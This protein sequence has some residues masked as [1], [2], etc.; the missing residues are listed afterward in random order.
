M[1]NV[2]IYARYSSHSQN[3]QSIEGQ[4]KACSDFA[5]QKDYTVIGEYIDR[6][7]SGTAADKRPE[8]QRMIADSAKHQFKYIVVY[9]LDRFSRNRYD[10]AVNKAKLKKNGVRLISVR[11]NITDDASGILMESVLEGM[12]EYF[13]AELSQKV[14]RGM[15]ISAS[16]CLSTG[17]SVALG[18]VVDDN[19]MFQIN[20][21]TAPAVVKIFELYAQGNTIAFICDYLNR[22]HIRT[23]RGGLFNKNSLAVLLSN[24]RYIGIY[25]YKGNETPG[26]MP[27][28]VSDELFNKVADIMDKNKKAPAR[29][30]AKEEFL[31]TTKLFCGKCKEM[32][33]GTSGTSQTG[34]IHYYYICNGRKKKECDKKNVIKEY[35]ENVVVK[36]AREQLTDNNIDLISKCVAAECEKDNNNL[37]Y[38]RLSALLRENEKATTNLLN[39]IEQ[40]QAVDII[41]QRLNQ[42]QQDKEE[43]EKEIAAETLNRVNLTAPEIRFF[44]THLRNG[45]IDDIKYRKLLIT[46]LVNAVYLYEDRYTVIF[47]SSDKPVEIT[48]SLI[49]EIGFDY[50]TEPC[51]KN[52]HTVDK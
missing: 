38:K 51:T 28:I 35:I 34:D 8:F 16:K 29:A 19:K 52:R 26:G 17:G 32:M 50:D 33:T 11:E 39:A 27:R 15:D 45:D 44:L 36:L 42:K 41:S 6:A 13:S 22:Q 21:D 5:A 48:Q 10:S 23:S 12:A 43:L 18:Y 46:V 2:V 30:R 14:R 47:N 25:I 1:S 24:K 4:I 7:M 40:G 3:E 31:L 49:D 20:A 37:N 9:Q